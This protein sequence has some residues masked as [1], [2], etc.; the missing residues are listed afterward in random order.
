MTRPCASPPTVSNLRRHRPQRTLSIMLALVGAAACGGE[1]P[2][3]P[4]PD[5]TPQGQMSAPATPSFLSYLTPDAQAV[6][7]VRD[8]ESQVNSW[9]AELG[10][11][12][13]AQSSTT[14]GNLSLKTKG[15]TPARGTGTVTPSMYPGDDCTLEYI[16]CVYQCLWTR[17]QFQG[18]EADFWRASTEFWFNYKEGKFWLNH[19]Q[20]GPQ[21]KM[22]GS[23]YWMGFYARRFRSLACNSYI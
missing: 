1:S 4:G 8:M 19:L 12:M 11:G 9:G 18:H 17:A 7:E 16:E 22:S 2:V 23:Y 5:A 3:A 13:G 14:T 20:G 10:T 6:V 15:R 21:D